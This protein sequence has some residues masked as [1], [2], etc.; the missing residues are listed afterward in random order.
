[1]QTGGRARSTHSRRA[2]P[3]STPPQPQR[4]PGDPRRALWRQLQPFPGARG[5]VRRGLPRRS[6]SLLRIWDVPRYSMGFFDLPGHP[7][8]RWSGLRAYFYSG[9]QAPLFM[10]GADPAAAVSRWLRK[11]PAKKSRARTE[12]NLRP[13]GSEPKV[14]ATTPR[15]RGFITHKGVCT[16]GH[17]CAQFPRHG[18]CALS[19]NPNMPQPSRRGPTQ[20][21]EASWPGRT[22]PGL[23]S[24]PSA[25]TSPPF[26]TRRTP[27]PT[28]GPALPYPLATPTPLRTG[29]GGRGV[30]QA[31]A[32]P[33]VR[34]LLRV[35]GVKGVQEGVWSDRT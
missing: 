23:P 27:L 6:I 18:K 14:R 4:P 3:P 11:N 31:A 17:L 12:S 7:P 2:S 35:P 16:L 28:Q 22:G 5:A 32:R 33:H 21:Q 34:H 15:A 24:L 19:L 8:F 9:Y 1:M 10:A 25:H 26:P 20:N 13:Q 29:G 30:G